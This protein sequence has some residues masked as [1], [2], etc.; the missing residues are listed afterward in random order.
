MYDLDEL[1]QEVVMDHNRRP[2]NFRTLE[3]ANRRAEG[4]NPLCGDEFTLYLKLQDDVIVEV[5]F[6]GRGCAIS[7][8]SASMMTESIKGKSKAE[9]EKIFE[10]FRHMVTREPGESTTPTLWAT[11][12]FFE[13]YRRT[14]C[15]S[16]AR[17]CRGTRCNRP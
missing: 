16:S 7:K 9:A 13:A 5:G 1:Y 11:W 2:R 14:R 6:Q 4:F 12:R 15:E 17:P 3:E 10:A 8:A